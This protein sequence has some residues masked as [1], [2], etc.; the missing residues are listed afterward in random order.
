LAGFCGLSGMLIPLGW[1][2]GFLDRFLWVLGFMVGL[3]LVCFLVFFFRQMRQR[4]RHRHRQTPK[5]VFA[6]CRSYRH[7]QRIGI[8]IGNCR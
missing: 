4:D 2:A 6:D 3:D 7:R 8:G 1:F 5:G